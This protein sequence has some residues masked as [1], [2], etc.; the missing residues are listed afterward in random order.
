MNTQCEGPKSF[1]AGAVLAANRRVKLD[2]SGNTVIYAGAGEK[3]IG[4]TQEAALTIGDAVKVKTWNCGGTFAIETAGAVTALAAVYG[5][6]N[7]TVDDVV[8]GPKIGEANEAASGAA[9]VIEVVV[10]DSIIAQTHVADASQTQDAIVDN[11]GGIAGTTMAVAAAATSHAITDSST[12]TASAT[13]IAEITA[14][15]NA[16]S[17]D[18][19]PVE[20]AIATLAAEAALVKTDLAT[21]RTEGAARA[22]SLAAQLAKVKTDVA[23][24]VTKVNSILLTLEKIGAHAAS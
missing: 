15:A 10:T 20:N 9:V 8:L 13:E 3:G 24:L 12:G 1:L 14:L 16:G 23:A 7:G 2:T 19:A 18:L 22:A 17:A 4:V 5:A 21:A 6:A 11:T